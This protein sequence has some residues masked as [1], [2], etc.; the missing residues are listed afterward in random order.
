V[1]KGFYNLTSDVWS[2]GVILYELVTGAVP[3]GDASVFAVIGM[4]QQGQKPGPIPQ[5]ELGKLMEQCW[6]EETERPSFDALCVSIAEIRQKESTTAKR[7][8]K[9]KK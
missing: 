1:F 5:G 4:L 8:R 6:A 9:G 3:F 2:F 7:N